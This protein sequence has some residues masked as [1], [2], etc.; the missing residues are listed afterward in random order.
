MEADTPEGVEYGLED[1]EIDTDEAEDRVQ[2]SE[3]GEEDGEYDP[4]MA[5]NVEVF[6]LI[7]NCSNC[8]IKS[9]SSLLA[10]AHPGCSGKRAMKWLWFVT[11]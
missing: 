8:T 6:L 11:V 5:G 9:R 3:Q 7:R 1:G 10:P 2:L 4:L